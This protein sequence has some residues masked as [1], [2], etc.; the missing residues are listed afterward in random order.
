MH[1][2]IVQL[3]WQSTNQLHTNKLVIVKEETQRIQAQ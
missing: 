2:N 3:K 1:R